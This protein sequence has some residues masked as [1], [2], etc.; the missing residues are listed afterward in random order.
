M[1][2]KDIAVLVRGSVDGDGDTDITGLSG[3]EGAKAG[4]LVFAID[5]ERL[6][7]AEKTG[8][9]C[10]LTTEGIRRSAKPLMRVSNP[11]LAF[12]LIYNA[13]NKPAA[14]KAYTDPSATVAASAKIGQNVWI[15]AGVRIGDDVKIGDNTIIEPNTVIKKGCSIGAF[16]HIHPN[17]TLYDNT[18]LKD[19]VVL[20]SGVVLGADGFGY[21]RDKGALYK[22]PQLGRVII[23][24]SVEIGANAAVDRGSLDDTIIGAGTKIDNFCQVAHNVKIGRNVVMAAQVGISGSVAIKDNVTIGGQAGFKDNVTI[25]KNVM[26]GAQS[27]VLND[28]P[29]GSIVWGTPAKSL[30]HILRQV[31]VLSWLTDNFARVK[32]IL[33]KKS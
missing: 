12:I 25:E 2:I 27:G 1:K 5:E 13:L 29:E 31:V 28:L 20:H 16:C 24:E 6:A 32:K 18:V 11:K 30:T 19:K 21:V 26:V 4:D 3:L 14:G 23:E 10:V 22:F 7:I 8:A 33:G 15:G 9:S 17:V